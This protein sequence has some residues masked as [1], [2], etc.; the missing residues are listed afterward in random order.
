M[1]AG[2]DITQQVEAVQVDEKRRY[3][4]QQVDYIDR[5]VTNLYETVC[6]AEDRLQQVLRQDMPNAVRGDEPA[7]TEAPPDVPL[8]SRLNSIGVQAETTLVHLQSLLDRLEV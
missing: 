5:T 4:H 6:R 2:V 1:Q 7:T 8:A 3:V